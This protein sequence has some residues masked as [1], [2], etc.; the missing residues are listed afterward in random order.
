MTTIMTT[1]PE[2]GC[3]LEVPH[4]TG[5]GRCDCGAWLRFTPA[6]GAQTAPGVY[7]EGVKVDATKGPHCGKVMPCVC[8]GHEEGAE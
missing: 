3:E 1:C 5:D 4:A 2:C 7:A 8:C 6:P